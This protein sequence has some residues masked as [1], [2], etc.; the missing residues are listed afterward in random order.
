MYTCQRTWLSI[1]EAVSIQKNVISLINIRS[2]TAHNFR[3]LYKFC[4]GAGRHCPIISR[5]PFPLRWTFPSILLCNLEPTNELVLRLYISFDAIYATPIVKYF[6]PISKTISIF[7]TAESEKSHK[8][9][10]ILTPNLADSK[11]VQQAAARKMMDFYN[12]EPSYIAVAKM[13]MEL[14]EWCN[15]TV[16]HPKQKDNPFD[17]ELLIPGI[18]PRAFSTTIHKIDLEREVYYETPAFYRVPT[19]DLNFLYCGTPK[20][21]NYNPTDFSSLFEPFQSTVWFAIILAITLS[22]FLLLLRIYLGSD[23]IFVRNHNITFGSVMFSLI[24]SLISVPIY[25][26]LKFWLRKSCLFVT[27]VFVCLILS[28]FYNG[29]VTS[30]LIQPIPIKMLESLRDLIVNNYSLVFPDSSPTVYDSTVE[31]LAIHKHLNNKSGAYQNHLSTII[32]SN[33]KIKLSNVEELEILMANPKSQY[34]PDQEYLERIAYGPTTA[35]F[36]P[37]LFV[38]LGYQRV[39]NL[40]ETRRSNENF[41]RD[42]KNLNAKR[43]CFVGKKMFTGPANLWMFYPPNSEWIYGTFLGFAQ[44]GIDK[45]WVR[46]FYGLNYAKRVQDRRKILSPTSIA[47]DPDSLAPKPIQLKGSHFLTVIMAGV[48]GVTVSICCF[49]MECLTGINFRKSSSGDRVAAVVLGEESNHSTIKFI[50]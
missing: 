17:N 16:V 27:W 46:E 28:N 4:K 42:S 13:M 38:Y 36:G 14:V 33:S 30:L 10:K 20:T 32:G 34:L 7:G 40:M 44:N 21:K 1:E 3:L 35:A 39:M 2:L 45:L 18:Y 43:R 37:W 41:N 15:L 47:P 8:F 22:S 26:G 29:I 24:S 12:I 9:I 23:T 5:S 49:L 25:F 31:L 50:P 48:V 11:I 6:Q 19:L